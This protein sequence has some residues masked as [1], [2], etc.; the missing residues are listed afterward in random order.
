MRTICG[1]RASIRI[2]ERAS[3]LNLPPDHPVCVFTDNGTLTGRVRFVTESHI[4]NCLKML[5]RAEYGITKAS[6]LA[7]YTSH[8]VRVG[9]CV[10][11]HAAG[12]N[13]MDIMHALRWRSMSFWN[14]LRNLPCQAARSM[15]AVRDFDPN[16]LPC[17]F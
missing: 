11:L 4:A 15:Q 5:A 3:L 1:C 8:S 17:P 13:Q 6:E 9:A 10:A 2:V 14:Y 12:V 7:L 16:V